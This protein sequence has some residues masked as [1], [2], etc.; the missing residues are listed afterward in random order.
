[1][2]VIHT[3]LLTTLLWLF[4]IKVCENVAGRPKKQLS[5]GW[6]IFAQE[7]KKMANI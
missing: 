1:M 5:C 3:L 6:A 7:L 2:M 4:F